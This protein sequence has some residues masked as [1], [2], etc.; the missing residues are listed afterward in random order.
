MSKWITAELR[1]PSWAA[2]EGSCAE[3]DPGKHMLPPG[4]RRDREQG[5]RIC[6]VR[7]DQKEKPNEALPETY[8]QRV[9]KPLVKSD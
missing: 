2:V 8:G 3:L 5:C 1:K 7:A 4:I 9:S 6:R